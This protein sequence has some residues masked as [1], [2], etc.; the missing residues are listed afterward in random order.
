M[1]LLI[2]VTKKIKD[3]TIF[4]NISLSI[5]DKGLTIL[6]GASGTGKT[7]LFD[8]ITNQTNYDGIVLIDDTLF[9]GNEMIS[10]HKMAYQSG[11][12]TLFMN[13]TIDANVKFCLDIDENL[14]EFYLKRYGLI[15][16][17][18][19]K[20]KNLSRGQI[21]LVKIIKSLLTNSD[22]YLFDEPTSSLDERTISL[23][24]EDLLKISN[25]KSVIVATHDERLIS[26]GNKIIDLDCFVGESISVPQT[27]NKAKNDTKYR[28]INLQNKYRERNIISLC[29]ICIT[30]ILLI[31]FFNSILDYTTPNSSTNLAKDE[32][33][34]VNTFNQEYN[35]TSEEMYKF[36]TECP[37]ID[38]VSDVIAVEDSITFIDNNI[39]I[40]FLPYKDV[41]SLHNIEKV[42]LHTTTK[43]QTG[44]NNKSILRDNQILISNKVYDAI[45]ESAEKI[46]IKNLKMNQ[47]L[48][49][50]YFEI[51]DTF[52]D[53]QYK[54][55]FSKNVYYYSLATR[56]QG[57]GS[58]CSID[59][60]NG[61]PDGYNGEYDLYLSRDILYKFQISMFTYPFD[62][63]SKYMV[64]DERSRVYIPDQDKYHLF[65]NN[66][67]AAAPEI[68]LPY[69]NQTI[70]EG[71]VP[72]G[73]LIQYPLYYKDLNFE[74][75]ITAGYYQ[76]NYVY[77]RY[78]PA[79]MDP[80]T[81]FSNFFLPS[82]HYRV[83]NLEK[84]EQ[85]FVSK[86]LFCITYLDNINQFD[87]FNNNILQKGLVFIGLSVAID[88]VLMILVSYYR[89]DYMKK[90]LFF[91]QNKEKLINK[92]FIANVTSFMLSTGLI[93]GFFILLL[94]LYSIYHHISLVYFEVLIIYFIVRILLTIG[95]YF[96]N[97]LISNSR[98][99]HLGR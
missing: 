48:F 99:Y 63:D 10:S 38:E 13:E 5:A 37:Y 89:D 84:A 93:L 9:K 69:E 96:I 58:Y 31:I 90:E 11:Y 30:I 4:D 94:F 60:I 80:K 50:S 54:I 91:G 7:T 73:D 27:Y 6:V 33:T 35:P 57:L 76:T 64:V 98:S 55:S 14:F 83:N 47:V 3:K 56:S 66:E 74:P 82:S 2:N 70:V 32:I 36:F 16:L 62:G 8:V 28:E 22:Y 20:L 29:S 34:L 21:Q 68:Y 86:N 53:E 17:R 79:L 78:I 42:P 65:I 85:Y 41:S 40:P 52:D 95:G 26:L 51:V 77:T 49:N 25:T 19:Q 92:E 24:I 18:F 72:E 75:S 44:M 71:S 67:I 12:E 39:T 23:L 88:I 61:Y 1:I 46:G 59:I 81:F 87:S 45:C 43:I 15:E 97:K